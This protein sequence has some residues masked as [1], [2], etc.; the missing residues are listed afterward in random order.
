MVTGL[1][2]RLAALVAVVLVLSVAAAVAG[3]APTVNFP[4]VGNHSGPYWDAQL[5]AL[6]SDLITTLNG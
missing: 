4:S 2:R 3:G 6:K 5:Q 1:W